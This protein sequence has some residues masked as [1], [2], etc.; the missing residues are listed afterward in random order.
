MDVSDDLDSWLTL[1]AIPG[2]AQ[3][4]WDRAAAL[5]ALLSHLSPSPFP[6]GG[7]QPLEHVTVSSGLLALCSSATAGQGL[8]SH[9]S[10]ELTQG[11]ATGVPQH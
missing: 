11:P 7:R 2:P 6:L 9:G 8:L 4:L 3:V 1:A 5:P 10:S